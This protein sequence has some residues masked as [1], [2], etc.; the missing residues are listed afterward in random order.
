MVIQ[1]ATYFREDIIPTLILETD[2]GEV[3]IDPTSIKIELL[4]QDLIY[5]GYPD[6]LPVLTF[7]WEDK[8]GKQVV[9]VPGYTN[10]KLVLKLVRQFLSDW[11]L[12]I[13][14]NGQVIYPV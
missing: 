10:D 6:Q 8:K 2:L 5:V 14:K 13:L 12:D 7:I 1:K 11:D 9:K 4:E 3:V